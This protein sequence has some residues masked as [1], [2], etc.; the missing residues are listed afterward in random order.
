MAPASAIQIRLSEFLFASN[1]S[2]PVADLFCSG[3]PFTS[4]TI[5][6][7][8]YHTTKQSGSSK[9]NLGLRLYGLKP[10]EILDRLC[11]LNPTIS[12]CRISHKSA[13]GNKTVYE[14]A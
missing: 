10:A 11:A 8:C 7:H 12:E 14:R 13:K 1:R 3:D 6:R 5:Q 9:R 2:S 4:F